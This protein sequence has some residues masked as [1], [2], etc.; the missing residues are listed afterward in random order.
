MREI[1]MPARR[2]LAPAAERRVGRIVG[3]LAKG[4]ALAGGVVLTALVLMTVASIAGR[5]L[6]PLGLR[7]IPGDFELVEIGC[8]FAVFAFLPWC[9]YRRGHVTVDLLVTPLGPRGLALLAAA[10][11]L[12]MTIA[13][14]L[15]A[16]R[17]VPG[18]LEKLQYQET[19][20]ILQIPVWWGYALGL[21]GAWLFV[22]VAAYTVW[23][24]L[25][26]ALSDGE[27][28]SLPGEAHR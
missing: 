9:Q 12:L 15:L 18:T 13:A 25:N 6:I 14:A 11:N 24:S 21:I 10:G 28:S 5:S 23:R 19:T 20:F 22:L 1:G 8:A 2:G 16:W 4:L 17:L 27:P 3:A 26:E 7:P